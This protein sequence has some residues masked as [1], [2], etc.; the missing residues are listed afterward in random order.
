MPE[1]QRS[2][3]R[4]RRH[5]ARAAGSDRPP[6]RV[7]FSPAPAGRRCAAGVA[8]LERAVRRG[9]PEPAGVPAGAAAVAAQKPERH[10]SRMGRPVSGSAR[11]GRARRSGRVSRPADLLSRH[12]TMDAFRRRARATGG[13]DGADRGR[14][15]DP[16]RGRG[17]R[18]R[19]AARAPSPAHRPRRSSGRVPDC[20]LRLRHSA[21]RLHAAGTPLRFGRVQYLLVSQILAITL[22]SAV[23]LWLLYGVRT[24]RA[25]LLATTP[26]R[27]E[28]AAL[29][30]DSRSARRA[31]RAGGHR[32][33]HDRGTVDRIARLHP[34]RSPSAAR[35]AASTRRR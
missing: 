14:A 2:A 32:R 26:D 16:G 13:A 8:R 23:G 20:G 33:G 35:S 22:L 6:A 28:P 5:E 17:C 34:A 9:G 25:P 4:D 18:G 3:A 24:L 27:M 7:P 21:G 1:H 11:H 12:R 31:R 30:P 10:A 15:V 19:D 29:R